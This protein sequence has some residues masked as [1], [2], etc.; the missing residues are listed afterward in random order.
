MTVVFSWPAVRMVLIQYHVD[1]LMVVGLGRSQRRRP[2]VDVLCVM[3]CYRC[4][5]GAVNGARVV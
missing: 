3:L 4:D 2:V 5:V 1:T